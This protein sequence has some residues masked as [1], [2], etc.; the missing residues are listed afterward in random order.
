MAG[1]ET[2]WGS[3][4]TRQAILTIV[5]AGVFFLVMALA[6]ALVQSRSHGP[7]SALGRATWSVCPPA[8]ARKADLL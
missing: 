3:P 8:A 2:R 4:R 5:L 6:F 7:A 1:P